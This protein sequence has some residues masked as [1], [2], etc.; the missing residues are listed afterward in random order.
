MS[1]KIATLLVAALV[2]LA[3]GS[4]AYA[5]KA[6]PT[7]KTA[8]EYFVKYHDAMAAA[9]TIEDLRPFMDADQQKEM[10][11]AS[12]EEKEMGVKMMSSMYADITNVKVVKETAK[13]NTYTLDVTATQASDKQAGTGTVEIVKDGASWRVDSETWKFGSSTMTLKKKK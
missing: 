6:A 1:R 9:K 10:D 11:A 3:L 7:A 5:Q 8:S 4:A 13:G 12:K 2:A